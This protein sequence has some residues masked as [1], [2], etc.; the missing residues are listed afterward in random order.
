MFLVTIT[1]SMTHNCD[2]RALGHSLAFPPP[3]THLVIFPKCCLFICIFYMSL[4]I[5]LF[6][7]EYFPL[8]LLLYLSV[9]WDVTRTTKVNSNQRKEKKE[10]KTF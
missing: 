4:C 10:E 1:G 8:R 3:M 5:C 9:C 7:L 2:V 6:Q